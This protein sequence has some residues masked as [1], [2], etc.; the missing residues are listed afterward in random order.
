MVDQLIG[1]FIPWKGRGEHVIPGDRMGDGGSVASPSDP[2]PFV[3]TYDKH[4]NK[5]K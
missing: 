4:N 5:C 1:A 2:N 3:L